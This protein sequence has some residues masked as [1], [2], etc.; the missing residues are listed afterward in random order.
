[1][2]FFIQIADG[3]PYQHPILEDNMSAKSLEGNLV[4]VVDNKIYPAR[5][6]MEGGKVTAVEP[7]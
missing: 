2:R 3:Q 1:M 7:I 4:D 5:V 6:T